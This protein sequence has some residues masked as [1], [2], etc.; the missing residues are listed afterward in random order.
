MVVT[1]FLILVI[2]IFYKFNIPVPIPRLN[3][4]LPE[5]KRLEIREK[6]ISANLV[7]QTK[8]NSDRVDYNNNQSDSDNQ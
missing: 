3:I 6:V 4:R 5:Q 2:W 7:K 8:K 1:L